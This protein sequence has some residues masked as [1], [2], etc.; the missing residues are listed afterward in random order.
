MMT[1]SKKRVDPATQPILD[2]D[3]GFG[4][5]VETRLVC[6]LDNASAVPAPRLKEVRVADQ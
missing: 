6:T 3:L 4:V 2:Q 5:H 1:S